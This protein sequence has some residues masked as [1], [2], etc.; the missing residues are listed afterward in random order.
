MTSDL[1]ERRDGPIDGL[2]LPGS[3][4]KALRQ[5]NITT[6]E[7]LRAVADK[8]QRFEGVGPQTAKIIRGEL[9]RVAFNK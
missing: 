3:A 7:Q 8:I 5:A 6:L 1:N 2:R 4:W 9:R